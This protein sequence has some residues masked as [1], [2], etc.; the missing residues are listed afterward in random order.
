MPSEVLSDKKVIKNGNLTMKVSKAEETGE[1]ISK[2]AKA[3]QGEI[4][5]SNFYQNSNNVKN[6]TIT[7][8]VPVNN[9]E[10]T[11]E[12][13][14]KAATLVTR[15]SISSQDATEQYADL[16]SRIRNKQAEEQS[17][18]KILDRAGTIGD[19]LNVTREISRVRGEIE[20]LQGKIKYL[21]SQTDM[22]TISINISEDAEITIT[23]S[24]RPLRVIKDTINLLFKDVQRFLNF[25]IVL[26][27]RVIPVVILYLILVLVVFI[28]GR[29]AY[30][31][32]K[33]KKAENENNIIK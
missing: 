5:S 25:A 6:G 10:K 8:K 31:K 23:D 20:V 12:E 32:I 1:E 13:L 9:F 30:R 18:I 4:F 3:N 21:S 22:A 29:K 2:I 33:S 17:F 27:I 26:I 24:W 19:V 28:F 11:F 15:E 7:V 16:E 14:K